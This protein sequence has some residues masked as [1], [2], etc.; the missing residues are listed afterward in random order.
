MSKWRYRDYAT[1]DELAELEALDCQHKATVA[2]KRRLRN[3]LVVRARA[4][5][6]FPTKHP[7]INVPR[8]ANQNEVSSAD[9]HTEA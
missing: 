4:R 2:A 7:R 9:K 5:Q 8:G 6:L 3:T 1:D